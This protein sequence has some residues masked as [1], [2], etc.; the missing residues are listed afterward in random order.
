[1]SKKVLEIVMDAVEQISEKFKDEPLDGDE[2]EL[3]FERFRVE[4][5]LNQG[6]LTKDDYDKEYAVK[7]WQNWFREKL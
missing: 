4:L 6:N 5:E 3:V 2:T 1:M 7:A